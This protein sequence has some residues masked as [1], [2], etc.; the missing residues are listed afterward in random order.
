MVETKF[1][2][3][4]SGIRLELHIYDGLSLEHSACIKP[5]R[6][7]VHIDIHGQLLLK[8]QV[9][10][11]RSQLAQRIMRFNSWSMQFNGKTYADSCDEGTVLCGQFSIH[12]DSTEHGD[13]SG[14]RIGTDSILV[15]QNLLGIFTGHHSHQ[16]LRL[17]LFIGSQLAGNG[18]FNLG[19]L[20]LAQLLL[21]VHFLGGVNVQFGNIVLGIRIAEG[22]FAGAV[23]PGFHGH[24]FRKQYITCQIA[25][26]PFADVGFVPAKITV[27]EYDDLFRLEIDFAGHDHLAGIDL[28]FGFVILKYI[29]YGVVSGIIGSIFNI[30][31]AHGG[32]I[33]HIVPQNVG[34]SLHKLNGSGLLAEDA[35]RQCVDVFRLSGK[36]HAVLCRQSE[37]GSG[38]KACFAVDL[39]T[40]SG[41]AYRDFRYLSAGT[42]I[43]TEVIQRFLHSHALGQ[44][45]SD[46]RFSVRKLNFRHSAE[47]FAHLL[48]IGSIHGVKGHALL[49]RLGIA[50]SRSTFLVH[51]PSTEGISILGGVQFFHRLSQQIF[52]PGKY[53]RLK[54]APPEGF[55][56][57]DRRIRL[58]DETGVQR[59]LSVHCLQTGNGSGVVRIFIPGG[60]NLAFQCG[61]CEGVIHH[62]AGRDFLSLNRRTLGDEGHQP[63]AQHEIHLLAGLQL[64]DLG[65][66]AGHFKSFLRFI[67]HRTGGADSQSTDCLLHANYPKSAAALYDHFVSTLDDHFGK[68]RVGIHMKID[69]IGLVFFI[70]FSFF[71]RFCFFI[72]FSFFVRFC[73]FARLSFFIR[74][75]F[76][77][78]Q[79]FFHRSVINMYAGNF[80]FTQIDTACRIQRKR[81]SLD[82]SQGQILRRRY[83]ETFRQHRADGKIIAHDDDVVQFHLPLQTVDRFLGIHRHRERNSHPLHVFI[84]SDGSVRIDLRRFFRQISFLCEDRKV[85]AVILQAQVCDTL[86]IHVKIDVCRVFDNVAQHTGNLP[87][88]LS[89]CALHLRRKHI[90]G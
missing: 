66:R 20:L 9:R 52:A 27:I 48:F 60:K 56:G 26:L 63:F 62:A 61:I 31:L 90:T 74:L 14:Q 80:A 40:V 88:Y 64:D 79:F 89:P 4:E 38:R 58:I 43:H 59:H 21:Q 47:F 45:Q 84:G 73:F 32:I 23:R 11:N 39:R 30:R 12:I 77:T 87:S 49:N 35:Y 34:Q 71:V 54:L 17:Q 33:D 10:S 72:R 18:L 76:F 15:I 57:N 13:R 29:K 28:S 67:D 24:D 22:D 44:Y 25:A 86:R 83:R 51:A 70:R 42:G 46:G 85:N 81:R 55:E 7:A 36:L 41:F 78:R 16:H 1:Y 69:H 82:R 53:Q 68:L 3:V 75:C 8:V 6:S 37:G 5:Q 50:E 2:V 65:V 19:D